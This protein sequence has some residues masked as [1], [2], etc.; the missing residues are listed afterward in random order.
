V[1][2]FVFSISL[3]MI[4]TIPWEGAYHFPGL[5]TTATLLGIVVSA[6]W[7]ALVLF[8]GEMK[9]PV[10]FFAVTSVFVLWIALTVFWSSDPLNSAGETLRWIG[11]LIITFILWDLY[12]TRDALRMGLQAYVLGAFVSIGGAFANYL[13]SHAFY[14]HYQRFSVGNTNPDGFGLIVALGVP[15]ACYLAASPDVTRR[16]RLVCLTYLPT[17]F[18]GIALSGTRTASIAA[19][20]GLLFGLALLTRLS[21]S[22]RIAVVALLTVGMLV[23]LP[24]V[25]PLKSFSRL[26]TTATNLTQGDQKGGLNGR[27][28]QWT[29]GMDAFAERPFFGVGTGMYRS[30][31]TLDKVAHNSYLSVAVELGLVGFI[32]FGTI[33]IMAF[34]Y[35]WIQP[36]WDRWFWLTVLAVWAIGASTLSWE[37]R[38]STWFFLTFCVISGTFAEERRSRR[39]GGAADEMSVRSQ[40]ASVPLPGG[41]SP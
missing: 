4:F 35:A 38:K 23:V 14:T 18:L 31:N 12:R 25:Q 30:V 24:I 16:M 6:L 33:L 17:A 32:L 2:K 39:L 29:Q 5:G 21:A 26:G 19:A 10:P 36:G 11:S 3:A 8:T 13:G 40:F 41:H 28:A 15:V 1:R 7:I 20:V 34:F 9:K 27:L 37:H 22:A